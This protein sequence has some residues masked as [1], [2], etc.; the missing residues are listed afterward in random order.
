MS[1]VPEQT[2][3]MPTEFVITVQPQRSSANQGQTNAPGKSETS[4]SQ[5]VDIFPEKVTL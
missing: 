4:I 5:N 2:C 1:S 3:E